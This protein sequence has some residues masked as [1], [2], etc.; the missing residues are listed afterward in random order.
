M[1]LSR[2]AKRRCLLSGGLVAGLLAWVIGQFGLNL[3]LVP[4]HRVMQHDGD[5]AAEAVAP[6]ESLRIAV[7]NIAHGRGADAG[8]WDG[9]DR[10]TRLARLEAIAE[11]LRA[12]DADVV[13]LN[14]VDFDSRWSYHIDQAAYLAE[15]AGYP[16][17]VEQRN[18]DVS[19]P[20]ARFRFGNVVLSR[21]P[22]SRSALL[23]YP[24]M[25]DWESRAAGQKHGVVCDLDIG[26]GRELRVVGIHLEH[27][28]EATRV[29]SARRLLDLVAT[30]DRPV[31]A[32]G[33][34]NSTRRGFPHAEVTGQG[35]TA[36]DVLLASGRFQA[37]PSQLTD[38]AF[39]FPTRQP[40]RVIDWVLTPPGWDF[41]SHQV[42][43]LPLSDHCLL[44]VDLQWP[45]ATSM[46]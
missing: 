41:T 4:G 17:R 20:F 1:R 36:I 12:A 19:V 45:V 33:D 7:Y 43:A 22:I 38:P 10:V 2:K 29:A 13:V 18:L 35:E 34:F 24:P 14:E 37:A 32:A 26:G 25:S 8:N 5:V 3:L 9:G 42:Q 16:H 46:L 21:R 39:T 15:A 30:S 11:Q 40:N 31:I 28:D 23:A 44:V 6:L 27:R